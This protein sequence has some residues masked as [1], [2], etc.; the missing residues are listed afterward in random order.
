MFFIPKTSV[1]LIG[2]ALTPS[3][4]QTAEEADATVQELEAAI[5]KQAKN[6]ARA[7]E[8]AKA[9]FALKVGL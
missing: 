4:C 3:I 7:Q 6:R 5:E 9:T 8:Q 1:L 2:L